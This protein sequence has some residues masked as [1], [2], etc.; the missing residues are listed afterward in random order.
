[1]RETTTI[2][3]LIRERGRKGLKLERL[4]R[5]LY[6]P[7][8]YEH[9]YGKL[10]RNK[11]ARTPGVDGETVDGMSKQKI[12]GMIEDIR[13][14]TYRWK[15]VRREYILKKDGELRP[16]GIPGW[17]DKLLQ[18]VLREILEAYYE[19]RFSKHSHGFRPD[20][21]V[22]TALSEVKESWTGT[23]WFIEGD[24]EDCFG[25]IDHKR[26]IGALEEVVTDGRFVNLLERL[27]QSGVMERETIT[28]TT[29]GIPQGGVIRPLLANIYMDKL[30]RYMT[31][32][33][34]PEYTKGTERRV[35]RNW[36][37]LLD[38]AG[39]ARKKGKTTEAKRLKKIANL[40]PS[41]DAYDPNFRRLYYIRYADD[42]LIGL[43][44]T[45]E[46]AEEI[47]EKVKNFLKE[48]LGLT[49]ATDKTLITHA[50]EE[51]AKFLGHEISVM[52]E[53]SQRSKD[54]RRGINGKIKL[55]LPKRVVEEKLTKYQKP[56]RAELTVL[57]DF[58]IVEKYQS[59]YRGLVEFY[60]LAT[61]I[62]D[63]DRV[64]YQMEKS[65]V[66]TLANK[67]R[68]SGPKIYRKFG[69]KVEGR[70]VL[71]VEIQREGKDPLTATWGG[72]RLRRRLRPGKVM[73]FRVGRSELEK[74]L[75]A[76]QCEVCKSTE[77]IEVHHIRAL[78]DLIAKGKK[79]VPF[80]KQWMIQRRRKTLVVC[81]KCHVAIH[82]GKKLPPK[83]K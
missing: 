67:H 14:E 31:E 61:N 60:R 44:G 42:F 6:N 35:N 16:L 75:Q 76:Q 13:K 70:P 72:I 82:N 43:I 59:E 23:A 26:L 79:T 27:L 49:L 56:H 9:A 39:R 8:L 68:T 50:R 80:W 77:N 33:L 73:K 65:L 34:I 53:N 74:R 58:E 5:L 22:H 78:K 37:N 4:Y 30:D 3:E 45:K 15:A 52:Q 81:H 11:G 2:H 83:D 47:R 7:D 51:R 21:S 36:K 18:E 48:N 19:E 1:M 38:R 62:A 32:Q 66:S 29:E 20:R 71:R 25:S 55:G 12:A 57:T 63:L 41:Y 54:G 40:L 28:P 46:E 64:K 69:S 24:I 17:T 10:Y